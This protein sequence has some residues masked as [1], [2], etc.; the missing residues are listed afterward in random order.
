M[1][2]EEEKD[3]FILLKTKFQVLNNLLFKNSS[4]Q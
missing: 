4:S 2:L 3:D 1:S